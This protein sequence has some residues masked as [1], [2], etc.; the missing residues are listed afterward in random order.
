M[1]F[2]LFYQLPA[3]PEQ[4]AAQRYAETLDQI[5]LGEALGFDTAW[6]A[7]MHFIPAYSVLPSPLVLAAAV[8]AR[9]Q[10]IRVGTA[11][12]LLPLHDPLRCAEDAAMVDVLSKGRL[13]LGIG[14]G[15][16]PEHFRGFGIRMRQRTDRF[17]EALQVL[18]RAWADSPLTFDG[19]YFH[20]D[21]INV[22]PKPV[23][24]PGPRL[25]MAAN[26]LESMEYA[27]REGLAVMVSPAQMP[28]ALLR[29]ALARYR[30]LRGGRVSP[31][32]VAV[33]A[34]VF[35]AES[36]AAA[37]EAMHASVSRFLR[38][39]ADAAFSGY[40]RFGG[41]PDDVPESLQRMNDATFED[42][43]RESALFGDA[44]LVRDGI[45]RLCEDLGAGHV[46]C[47]FNAGGLVP[48]AQVCASMR[49]FAEQV[50]DTM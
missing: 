4:N 39:R 13:E 33:M 20:Y 9:T 5:V 40:L 25:R 43:V 16:I 24:R 38:V 32:D 6:L 31:R 41:D 12:V 47:W 37:Q 49:R 42:V 2:G 18:T 17:H 10:R 36:A 21:T 28:R 46:L 23:Q 45:A 48:H 26:S 27:G 44:A 29:E 19:E 7:E 11:V 34:P 15:G 22:V 1:E 35:V 14:R 30:E 8:A 3:A 50:S